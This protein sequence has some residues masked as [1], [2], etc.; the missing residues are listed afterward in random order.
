MIAASNVLSVWVAAT[1]LTTQTIVIPPT[2]RTISVTGQ[3]SVKVVP[4][5]VAVVIGIETLNEDLT[6]AKKEHDGRVK[7]VLALPAKFQIDPKDVQTD[8][9]RIDIVHRWEGGRQ[10]FDRYRVTQSVAVTLREVSKYDAFVTAALEAGANQLHQI[11]FQTS[12]L[13]KHR[14]QARA[15]AIQAA[16]EKATAMA[17]ELNQSIGNPTS[18]QEY[19]TSWWYGD[20]WRSG[21]ASFGNAQVQSQSESAPPS[22]DGTIA[23]GQLRVDANISVTFELVD[24][25]TQ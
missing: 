6:A 10:Y 23:L 3:A 1:G 18:I 15:L 2:T 24:R 13:R 4:D 14:D 19:S 21:N 7:K 20:G 25:K 9:V 17:G 22:L 5:R 11:S 8:Y 12:E 16:K